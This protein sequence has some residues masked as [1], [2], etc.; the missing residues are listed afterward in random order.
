MTKTEA[1]LGDPLAFQVFNEIGIIEQLARTAFERVLPAGLS[2]LGFQVLNHF[3]RLGHTQ[4]PSGL[5]RAFQVSKAA[6]TF[7]LQRLEAQGYVTL[8]PDP[9]DGRGKRVALTEAGAT[10]R[11]RAIAALSP[12]IAQLTSEVPEADLSTLLPTLRRVRIYL[13]TNRG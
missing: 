13:D 9:A 1:P 7:T 3:V 11:H 5:A 12:M 4:T 10:I 6:M 2:L 8:T